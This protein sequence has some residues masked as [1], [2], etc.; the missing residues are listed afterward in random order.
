MEKKSGGFLKF[1]LTVNKSLFKTSYSRLKNT[2]KNKPSKENAE[3]FAV[4]VMRLT[5]F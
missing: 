5:Y 2:P 4:I 3:E 1:G